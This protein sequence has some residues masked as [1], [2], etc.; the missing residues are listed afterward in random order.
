MTKPTL[1]LTIEFDVTDT[2]TESLLWLIRRNLDYMVEI[3]DDEHFAD[4][5]RITEATYL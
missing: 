2:N 1:K 3:D 5:C 4:F